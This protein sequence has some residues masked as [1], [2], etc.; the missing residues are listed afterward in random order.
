LKVWEIVENDIHA[1]IAAIEPL[2]PPEE[3]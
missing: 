3:P 2:V 1:L